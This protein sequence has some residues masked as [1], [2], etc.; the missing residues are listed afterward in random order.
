[1][2]GKER[3]AQ[4]R[5]K[6]KQAFPNGGQIRAVANLFKV[7]YNTARWDMKAAGIPYPDTRG[8]DRARPDRDKE[9]LAAVQADPRRTLQDIGDQF[10][11]TKER[12]RQIIV[13]HTKAPKLDSRRRSARHGEGVV[14]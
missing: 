1:M 12:V 11:L 7:S 9:L 2:T 4:R 8:W 5:A 10:G 13:K 6:M 14:A 3:A